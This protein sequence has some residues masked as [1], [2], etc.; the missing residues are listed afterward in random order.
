MAAPHA[1]NT[2]LQRTSVTEDVSV[3]SPLDTRS[4]TKP[5]ELAAAPFASGVPTPSVE[6]VWAGGLQEP[7]ESGGAWTRFGLV[8]AAWAGTS[9]T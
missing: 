1:E 9:G 8:Q 4:F 5:V 7:N 2:T 6:E 3:T